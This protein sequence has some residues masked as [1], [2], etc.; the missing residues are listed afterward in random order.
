V[1]RLLENLMRSL[2]AIAFMMLVLNCITTF[3]Y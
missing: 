1:Q 2:N 3:I